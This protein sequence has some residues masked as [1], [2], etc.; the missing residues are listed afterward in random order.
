[1]PSHWLPGFLAAWEAGETLLDANA[2]GNRRVESQ[3]GDDPK[4]RMAMTMYGNPLL[5][6]ADVSA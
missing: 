4:N 1:M 5:R 6:R 3:M 2:A